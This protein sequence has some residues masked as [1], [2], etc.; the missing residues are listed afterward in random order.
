M[1]AQQC[2]ANNHCSVL[3]RVSFTSASQCYFTNT[4][5]RSQPFWGGVVA[6]NGAGPN[7]IPHKSL[8]VDNLTS[9]IQFAL[10]KD[11]EV[12]AQGIASRMLQE[13]GVEAAVNFFHRHLPPSSMTC[14]LLPTRVARWTYAGKSKTTM[15][16]SDAALKVLLRENKLKR[17]DIEP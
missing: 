1:W 9:G 16:L 14:D 10:S 12:A 7:P 3:R 2:S 11:A 15:K 13:N 6:S 4:S 5:I 8:N 17:S